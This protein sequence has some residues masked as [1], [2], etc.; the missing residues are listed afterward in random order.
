MIEEEPLEESY[1][2][3]LGPLLCIEV[4]C[5]TSLLP[6]VP[7]LLSCRTCRRTPPSFPFLVQECLPALQ[8]FSEQVSMLSK[9]L[10][11]FRYLTRVT[12][13]RTSNSQSRSLEC[14][15]PDVFRIYCATLPISFGGFEK[16]NLYVHAQ[17]QRQASFEV[18]H[19]NITVASQALL[20]L[21]LILV[22][23]SIDYDPN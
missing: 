9:K 16:R 8:S 10:Y 4:N 21:T 3:C 14:Y 17:F 7:G 11:I 18:C 1:V 12:S 5:M 22:T 23:V 19:C 6:G 13:L 15:S 2:V 20:S